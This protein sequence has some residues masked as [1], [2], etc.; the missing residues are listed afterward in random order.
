MFDFVKRQVPVVKPYSTTRHDSCN[1]CG[2]QDSF[3]YIKSTI[4]KLFWNI[5]ALCTLVILLSSTSPAPGGEGFEIYLNSKLVV[6]HWGADFQ[7]LKTIQLE[8]VT[9]ADKLKIKYYHCG[10][11]AKNRTVLIQT[12][13]GQT[14]KTF[15]YPDTAPVTAMEVPLGGLVHTKSTRLKL[16]YSSSELPSGRTIATLKTT[17][18]SL[19]AR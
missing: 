18:S 14:L 3:F 10:R 16:F 15:R 12:E 1:L 2:Q 17:S 9:A 6:Q 19:A 8:K 4:M 7:E 11:S 5:P 13:Q